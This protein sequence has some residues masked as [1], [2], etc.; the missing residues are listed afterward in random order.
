MLLSAIVPGGGQVYNESYLK[1]GGVILIEGYF[2]GSLLY[3]NYKVN[4]HYDK[5]K[6]SFDDEYLHHRKL[7][8]RHYRRR[9]NDYWWLGSIIFLSAVDAFVDASLFNFEQEKDRIGIM[10]EKNSIGININF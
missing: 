3:N 6:I 7:Y 8:N 1:A 2:I 4:Y 5:A 10:F 9:Q